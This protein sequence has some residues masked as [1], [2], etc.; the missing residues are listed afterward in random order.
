MAQGHISHQEDVSHPS[1]PASW[2][3]IHLAGH[4]LGQ[5]LLKTLFIHYKGG[6]IYAWCKYISVSPS[7]SHFFAALQKRNNQ[8]LSKWAFPRKDCA[9][10]TSLHQNLHQEQAP[11]QKLSPKANP[12]C[13]GCHDNTGQLDRDTKLDDSRHPWS[14]RPRASCKNQ[15]CTATH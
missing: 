5:H 8:P 4:I 11:H 1:S 6:I 7:F 9:S 10:L 15:A 3:S 2:L 13:R 14:S 12:Y